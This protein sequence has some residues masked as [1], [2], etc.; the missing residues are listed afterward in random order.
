MTTTSPVPGRDAPSASEREL[1][2]P[3]VDIDRVRALATLD[4]ATVPAGTGLDA[5]RWPIGAAMLQFP[6][7]A[8]GGIGVREAGPE[9]WCRQLRRI[10]RAGFDQVEIPSAWLPLGD[11]GDAERRALVDVLAEVGLGI[12]AASVVRRSIVSVTD[13][14]QNM[15]ATH[16]AIDAAAAV[17]A[18]L[19]CLGLHE[20][21]RP[22]QAA[23]PWFWT[24]P[25]H[26]VAPDPELWS[27]AVRRF[28]ELGRHAG[29]VGV[30]LSIEAY[31]GTFLG[32]S[33]HAVA[34]IGDVGMDGVG[35]NPD[36][37]N[38]IRQPGPI[39]PWEAMAVKML[40]HANYWHVKNY[41]RAEDPGR[42]IYLSTP[43][44]PEAGLIDYR[45]AVRFAIAHGFRG[46]LLCENYGGDGLSVSAGNARYLRGVLEDVL[47]EN[48]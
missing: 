14:E 25:G 22:E 39:E 31:E 5:R 48:D 32:D 33:D 24:V 10:A 28:R 3:P 11:M 7:V 43:C 18:P 13:G 9:Y 8:P 23:V 15:A 29:E 4:E 47:T 2:V 16:R 1:P 34:F 35:L 12:C 21:L 20:P 17:G 6:P 27:L 44:A 30:A 41:A 36:L 45:K 42:G 40:P 46:A 38:L 26:T 19:V 37:G